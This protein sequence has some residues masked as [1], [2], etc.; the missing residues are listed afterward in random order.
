MTLKVKFNSKIVKM[1]IKQNKVAENKI[2]IEAAPHQQ[3]LTDQM[4]KVLQT[5]KA[6]LYEARDLAQRTEDAVN[7]LDYTLNETPSLLLVWEHY[8]H[9]FE[10]ITILCGLKSC[11][12]SPNSWSD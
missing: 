1:L 8:V 11:S 2:R 12:S 4:L 3:I 10:G 7:L 6:T 9:R 5:I